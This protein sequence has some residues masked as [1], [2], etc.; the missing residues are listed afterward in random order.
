[1][2]NLLICGSRDATPAMLDYARRCVV[3]A[4]ENGWHVIVGDASGVDTA[5]IAECMLTLTP[6]TVYG[7][8]EKPRVRFADLVY[9]DY[10]HPPYIQCKGDF[11]ARDRVMAEACDKCIGIWNGRS[12]GTAYTVSYAKRECGKE[13]WLIDMSKGGTP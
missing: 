2:T 13:T 12:R 7:I 8:T 11:L 9:G 1:M 3:R 4:R 6:V 10:A 5:V